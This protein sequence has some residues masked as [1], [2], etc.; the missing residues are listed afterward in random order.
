MECLAR[1]INCP[2]FFSREFS[3]CL[4]LF[5]DTSES[6]VKC[7][8]TSFLVNLSRHGDFFVQ[9]LMNNGQTLHE[10]EKYTLF[11]FK[12]KKHSYLLVFKENR[13]I[14]LM[15]K[16]KKELSHEDWQMIDKVFMESDWE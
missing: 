11:Q 9:D 1:Q 2:I 8:L 6:K 12:H 10:T 5:A 7:T 3:S 15:K 14:T 13:I 4:E 16:K